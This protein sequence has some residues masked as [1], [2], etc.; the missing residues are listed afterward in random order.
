MRIDSGCFAEN[1][2]RIGK[3]NAT[4]F[5]VARSA[6]NVKL[7]NTV[8][9]NGNIM[10]LRI[11]AS[12]Y[13]AGR[14]APKIYRRDD[15]KRGRLSGL[16]ISRGDITLK[17]G[18][19]EADGASLKRYK[20]MKNAAFM[21]GNLY[22]MKKITDSYRKTH[23]ESADGKPLHRS[24]KREMCFRTFIG[25]SADRAYRSCDRLSVPYA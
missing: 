2:D 21:C 24:G 23:M 3:P 9:F 14:R 25:K 18:C 11:S 13:T 22:R 7:G 19:A 5:A 6:N 10:S 12:E 15:H 4:H 8:L 20:R 17:P 16:G 1:A